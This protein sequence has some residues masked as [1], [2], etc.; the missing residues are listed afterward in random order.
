M[1]AYPLYSDLRSLMKVILD[2]SI[3]ANVLLR[4]NAEAERY[5]RPQETLASRLLT[6]P[7]IMVSISTRLASVRNRKPLTIA[8][9]T[10]GDRHQEGRTSSRHLPR[11]SLAS[12][13]ERKLY[14]SVQFNEHCPCQAS[15]FLFSFEARKTCA[16]IPCI[17]TN[18]LNQSR[19][20][21]LS[22]RV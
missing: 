8:L 14:P 13:D 9:F 1:L 19:I 18:T 2:S 17:C 12:V 3:T 4:Q 10:N 20:D 22:V 15:E 6:G 11:L 7:S 16:H 21:I 5:S